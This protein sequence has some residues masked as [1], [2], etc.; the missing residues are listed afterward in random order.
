MT[1]RILVVPTNHGS[2]LTSLCLGLIQALDE[3]GVDVGYIKPLA[4][5]HRDKSDH[6]ND[7]IRL[8]TPLQPSDPIPAEEVEHDLA[9]GLDDTL[10][11]KVV[12]KAEEA[13]GHDVLIIEGLVPSEV[14]TYSGRVNRH[15]AKALDAEVVLCAAA[16]QDSV[17]HIAAL[18]QQ[19]EQAYRV[20]ESRRV[21]GAVL[22]MTPG[23]GASP[24]TADFVSAIEGLGIPV[25]GTVA[26]DA[27]LT[28]P[29]VS[30]LVS[31]LD[32]EILEAGDQERRISSTAVM[33]RSV[34][35]S[36][37][38]FQ[39]GRLLV[40]PGDRDD[41]I[42]SS[43]LVVLN[44]TR[45]AAMLLTGGDDLHPETAHAMRGAIATGL[46]ILRTAD[47]TFEAAT[48]VLEMNRE[49]PRDDEARTRLTMEF[50]AEGLNRDWVASLATDSSRL[51]LSPAAFRR[52]L[53]TLAQAAHKR[54][55][56]PEGAEPR[57]VEAAIKCQNRG[58]ARC[59]LLAPREEVEA[60]AGTL[61][62]ELPENIE[63]I[64]P[65][66]VD[67]RYV[68]ALVERRKHKGMTEA[69]AVEQLHDTVVLGTVMVHL[70]EVDGLVSGAV[71]T[72]ANT[73]RPALQILGTKPGA[74]L[75]SSVFFMGLPDEVV[76]YGD[77]AIN[78][79]PN[80]EELAD[81]AI[82]SADSA[83]AFGIEP[84][85]AMIS[86]STGDSGAGADVVK[87]A[88]ATKIV[89]ELRP[90]IDVDGPLQYDAAT[91]MSVA[92]SKAPNSKVAGRATVFIFPDLN[93]GNT[94]YKAVQ[95]S[96][97]VISVGPMLQGI[98]APVNDLSRGAL[99]E[100]IEYT[101]AL[102]AIQAAN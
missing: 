40:V 1:R 21:I 15:L 52:K 48:R 92:Q 11:E 67:Q 2:G 69:A 88:E 53:T 71:H 94:T 102:T 6:T 98:A 56:L 66:Q 45:I 82:Q 60:V 61:G 80:A 25:V 18:I 39:D 77:C 73:V 83:R 97:S 90:D 4:Q 14:Q 36:L 100:D 57:T 78:P 87:V 95:R 70:G 9:R 5:V 19:S 62:L 3:Q 20:G 55:V 17:D 32:L 16:R 7:L 13:M 49:I 23:D 89:R 33:A 26:Y 65:R 41:V 24:S 38:T 81:I 63:I 91:T 99:V 68:D 59:V 8:V 34:V 10:M 44:G 79:D 72:T 27:R 29:R 54:I 43:A 28:W 58:I 84:R 12:A 31:E 86:F 76:V 47:Y 46:P 51:R 37:R 85:V 30:D 75:V 64:D 22:T 96:A 74:K 42:I 50:F 35:G 101:I 93:T